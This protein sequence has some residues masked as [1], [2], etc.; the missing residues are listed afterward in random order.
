MGTPTL[1]RWGTVLGAALWLAGCGPAD[2]PTPPDD[3]AD[4]DDAEDVPWTHPPLDADLDAGS[5][6]DAAVGEDVRPPPHDR[7]PIG[8]PL[9]RVFVSDAVRGEGLPCK[10]TV[11]GLGD[12]PD[13]SWG[14]YDDRGTWIDR[15]NRALAIGHWLLMARGRA[16][17][18]LPPGRYR[19]SVT[20]GM[21]YALLDLGDIEVTPTRGATLRGDLRRVIDTEGEIA[22]EFH[23]HSAPSFDCAVPLDQRVL[24]L[25]AEGIEV[26]A[27]TDHD[28]AADFRPAIRSLGLERFIHWIRGDEITADGFGH[29]NVFPLPDAVDPARDLTHDEPSLGAILARARRVAPGALLQ[30]NHPMWREYPIGHWAL[31]GFDPA[32][33]MSRMELTT[34]F[35]TVEVWNG[36]SLNEGPE[37]SVGVERVLDAWMATLQLGRGATAVGNSDSHRVAHNPPGWPRTYVRVPNDHPAQ[38]STTMVESALRAGDASLTS[39]PFLRFTVNGV[40]PG[41]RAQGAS[42]S[43]EIN[44]Q[45]P[46]FVP[47]D[48]VQVIAN[49]VVVRRLPVTAR[50]VDGVLRQSWT[51]PLTLSRDAWVL[52]RTV[53]RTPLPEGLVGA[54]RMPMDSLGL[55]NP[56][57]VDADN[58]G[59]YQPPGIGNG[60]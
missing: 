14:G 56:V 26:F 46:S 57:Y 37:F 5:E 41:A 6:E 29:F 25:A 48:E 35:D 49:R 59:Q 15:E 42:V 9:V 31:A 12:T 43:V 39:G 60:P 51:V 38:V 53:A 33:G 45:A 27:S 4:T 32:T 22:G 52:T 13:P 19:L 36:H 23:V 8:P 21:E 30:L 44:L 54:P 17:F 7:P 16:E 18:R 1:R 50:P 11:R 34:L 10:L 58:D 40:R 3:V 2:P 24:G 28:V 20:R 55:V 47:V